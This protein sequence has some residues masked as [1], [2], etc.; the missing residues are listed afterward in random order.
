MVWLDRPLI[1]TLIAI[2]GF[3]GSLLSGQNCPGQVLQAASPPH[4]KL[5]QSDN[6]II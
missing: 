4:A 6:T 5:F 1:R 2:E 3:G